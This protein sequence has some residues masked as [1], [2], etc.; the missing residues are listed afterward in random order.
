[1]VR[2]W[3]SRGDDPVEQQK[4]MMSE[5]Q[6]QNLAAAGVSEGYRQLDSGEQYAD[7]LLKLAEGA[8]MSHIEIDE[9][10][11]LASREIP[12]A[13]LDPKTELEEF[14]W[15]LRSLEQVW[16]DMHPRQETIMQGEWMA[17]MTG[18]EDADLGYLSDATKHEARQYLLTLSMR[19]T[20]AKNGFQQKEVNTQHSESVV[21][22][23][24][25]EEANSRSWIGGWR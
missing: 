23:A 12:L 11:G 13:N 14:K 9:F 20:R 16:L 2:G 3:L 6:R 10:V 4:E 21:R 1:M 17:A 25:E 15:M 8:K 7:G 19:A 24:S 22:D 18:D 5:E